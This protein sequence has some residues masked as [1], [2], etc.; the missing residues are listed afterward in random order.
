MQGW[1]PFRVAPPRGAAREAEGAPLR[2]L[3]RFPRL[4]SP[5]PSALP[6]RRL[7]FSIRKGAKPCPRILPLSF[8][9]PCRVRP[10]GRASAAVG[11]FPLVRK[12][13]RRMP[14]AAARRAGERASSRA[15]PPS[16]LARPGFVPQENAGWRLLHGE[17]RRNRPG[18]PGKGGLPRP[19]PLGRT[20]PHDPDRGVA[21]GRRGPAFMTAGAVPPG[22][23][24]NNGAQRPGGGL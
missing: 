24:C 10:A 21:A 4:P 3:P 8:F 9:C 20:F 7:A 16:R 12:G 23:T 17:G 18:A 22:N 2:A 6:S 1:P 13:A 15:F 14:L 5:L 19:G 11:R